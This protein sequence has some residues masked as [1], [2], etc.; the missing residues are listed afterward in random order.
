MLLTIEDGELVLRR[1][2]AAVT[3]GLV[4]RGL[5]AVRDALVRPEA[6]VFVTSSIDFPEEMTADAETI[7]FCHV[8]R[9][10]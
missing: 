10:V 8:L 3:E 4:A 2:D 9:S 7:E 1:Y 5:S 6:E